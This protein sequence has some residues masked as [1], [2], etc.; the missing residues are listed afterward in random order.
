MTYLYDAKKVKSDAM[1]R[2]PEIIGALGGGHRFVQIALERHARGNKSTTGCPVH[3]EDGTRFRF[4]RDF[5]QEGCC[6]VS[7]CGHRANG[8]ETL[9]WLRGW[10]YKTALSEVYRYLGGQPGGEISYEDRRMLIAKASAEREAETIQ[11]RASLTRVWAATI[12]MNDMRARPAHLYLASRGLTKRV[13]SPFLRFHPALPY[14]LNGKNQ[15]KFPAIVMKLISGDGSQCTSIHRHY[16]T[17][18][19]QKAPF[20]D[21]KK[22]MSVPHDRKVMGSA[23]RLDEVVDELAVAEGLETALSVRTSYLDLP[24]WATYSS[25]LMA[26]LVLPPSLK[27]LYVF[28]DK[29]LKQAGQVAASTLV[30]R[31]RASGIDAIAYLPGMEIPQGK[32]TVDWNDALQRYG[33]AA[34]PQLQKIRRVA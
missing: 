22:M 2:W 16:L 14:Y 34:F 23:I 3:D 18:D 9:M 8:F 17:E 31:A 21:S 11:R 26:G 20:E 19:G 4:G 10:D 13:L 5:S 29:D 25:D 30:K 32:K 24:V 27:R 12:P 1:G 33:T 28:A 6:Y 15:G 7:C